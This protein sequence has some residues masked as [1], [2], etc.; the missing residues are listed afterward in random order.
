MSRASPLRPRVLSV[1]RDDGGT[2]DLE[3]CRAPLPGTVGGSGT[4]TADLLAP[5]SEAT[6]LLRRVRDDATAVFLIL[7]A[8]TL[9]HRGTPGGGRRAF[10]ILAADFNRSQSLALPRIPVQTSSCPAAGIATSSCDPANLARIAGA[11]VGLEEPLLGVA[12]G[13]VQQR[14]RPA[15]TVGL[16]PPD[17]PEPARLVEPHCPGVLLV[18]IDRQRS[19]ES[20]RM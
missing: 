15:V 16:R 4:A 2:R 6:A 7:L 12:L 8:P 18:D 13:E 3:D 20:A 9:P 11:A 17:H 14:K 5:A 19:L 1:N 10:F